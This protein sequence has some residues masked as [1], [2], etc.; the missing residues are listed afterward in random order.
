M[1]HPGS[2]CLSHPHVT[3]IVG[4]SIHLLLNYDVELKDEAINRPGLIRKHVISH[5]LALVL[6]NRHTGEAMRRGRTGPAVTEL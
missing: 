1:L 2:H 5:W 3:Q 4:G 6:C